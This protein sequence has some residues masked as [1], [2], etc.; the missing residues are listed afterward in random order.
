MKKIM[1][2][3]V[4]GIV[5]SALVFLLAYPVHVASE[6]RKDDKYL[7]TLD[8]AAENISV[9]N[10]TG[11][12][13]EKGTID[14]KFW[15]YVEDE[16]ITVPQNV[17]DTVQIGDTTDYLKYSVKLP[18]NEELTGAAYSS[19]SVKEEVKAE[20][21]QRKQSYTDKNETHSIPSVLWLVV[22]VAV[23]WFTLKFVRFTERGYWQK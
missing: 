8:E 23:F 13:T 2:I 6:M 19:D 21:D 22:A 12:I 7:A 18:Q 20:I 5:V 10:K 3:G 15:L 9:K 4:I 11:K 1:I 16:Q 17:Y 14:E